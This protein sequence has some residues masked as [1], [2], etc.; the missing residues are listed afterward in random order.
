MS[1]IVTIVP[2]VIGRVRYSA[3]ESD[4]TSLISDNG[5]WLSPKVKLPTLIRKEDLLRET[6]ENLGAKK[7]VKGNEATSLIVEIDHYVIQLIRNKNENYT[8]YFY[9]EISESKAKEFISELEDEYGNV[10]QNQ[11][12]ETLK[13]KAEANGMDLLN[14]TVQNDQTIVLT[15]NLK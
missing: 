1:V 10:V 13:K 11:V 5:A 15:Y 9:G 3:V 12:Y 4:T 6:L 2:V 8:A 7:I 14:E